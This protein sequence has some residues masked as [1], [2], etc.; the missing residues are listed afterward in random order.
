MKKL[1]AICLALVVGASMSFAQTVTVQTKAP[2]AKKEMVKCDKQCDKAVVNHKCEKAEGTKCEQAKAEHK[3]AEAQKCE[4]SEG[5]H[6]CAKAE[7]KD[8]KKIGEMKCAKGEGEHKCEKGEGHKCEKGEGHKCEK[9]EGEHKCAKMKGEHKCVKAEGEGHKCEKG[10]GH[11]CAKEAADKKQ[12]CKAECE[13]TSPH[14]DKCGTA[15]QQCG[16]CKDC[17]KK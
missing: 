16:D 1:L 7:G 13:M 5:E 3:C 10:E 11:K 14:C 9:A 12:C 15:E 4:K 2:A 6:K 8:L 17:A